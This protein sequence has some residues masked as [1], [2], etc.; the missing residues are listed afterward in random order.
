M[1]ASCALM[2]QANPV[3]SGTRFML[4]TFMFE[5]ADEIDRRLYCERHGKAHNAELFEWTRGGMG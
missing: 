2:H 3:R 1:P 4:V 5:K